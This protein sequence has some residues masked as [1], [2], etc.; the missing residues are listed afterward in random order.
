MKNRRESRMDNRG[1]RMD[2]TRSSILDLLSSTILCIALSGCS[3]VPAEFWSKDRDFSLYG[4]YSVNPTTGLSGLGVI[5]YE[6]K[7]HDDEKVSA[8]REDMDAIKRILSAVVAKLYD[9]A[10]PEKGAG[11]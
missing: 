11:F 5:T 3:S 7:K 9:N 1:W 4:L 8:L 10:A 2:R 6:S